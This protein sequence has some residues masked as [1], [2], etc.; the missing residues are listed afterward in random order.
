MRIAVVSP[1]GVHVPGGVQ[2]QVIEL[3]RWLNQAGHEAFVVAPKAN[4]VEGGIDAGRTIGIRAN[5]A[6][7]PVA[8]SPAVFSRVREELD[9]ADLV[10]VHE[11]FMPLVGWAGLRADTARVLTF[12][13]DPST[14]MR[15]LYR[16][17]GPLLRSFAKTAPLSAVSPTAASAIADVVGS[18]VQ[19]PN[20]LDVSSYRL[21]I[22]RVPQQVAF[23]GR[24]EPRKGRDLLLEAWPAVRAANPQ[25]TLIIMGSGEHASMDGVTFAGRVD[26][27]GKRRILAS[28]EVF[29]APNRGGESFGITLAEGMAAGCATIAS[30]LPAFVDLLND[31]GVHFANGM[32]INSSRR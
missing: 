10:H 18:P 31:T 30:D 8:L 21:D 29:C 14:V 13:A 25:A 4:N 2:Q 15:R 19:I 9:G 27:E 32:H 26:E 1:Y 20:A 5:G 17:A 28:S 6:V 16:L 12:H 11:P 22:G 3:S 24:P 23:L 7:A